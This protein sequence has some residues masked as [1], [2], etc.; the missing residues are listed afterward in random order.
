MEYKKFFLKLSH[1]KTIFITVVAILG[2]HSQGFQHTT[3]C[4]FCFAQVPSTVL[5]PRICYRSGYAK[6]A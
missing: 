4:L 1:S 6:S 2:W 5:Q 3:F